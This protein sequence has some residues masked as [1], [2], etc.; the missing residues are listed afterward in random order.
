LPD[1]AH[2][3]H[4]RFVLFDLVTCNAYVRAAEKISRDPIAKSAIF[5]GNP[6]RSS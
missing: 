6:E 1:A 3:Q 4:V 5:E 2:V